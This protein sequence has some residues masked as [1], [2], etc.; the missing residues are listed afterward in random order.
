[1]NHEPVRVPPIGRRIKAAVATAVKDG[2]EPKSI[3]L[4]PADRDELLAALKAAG[5]WCDGEPEP[6]ELGGLALRRV[7]GRGSSKLYC[8][9]GIGRAIP[10]RAPP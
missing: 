8:R 4:T 6:A 3:Y 9:H 2:L 1:M 7:G 5:A 10:V